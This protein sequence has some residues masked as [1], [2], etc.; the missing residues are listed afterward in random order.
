VALRKVPVAI[1]SG[2]HG[3]GFS[4]GS[5]WLARMTAAP[6]AASDSAMLCE[7]RCD[8]S[9]SLGV[10]EPLSPRVRGKIAQGRRPVD[11]VVGLQ[12]ADGSWDLTKEFAGAV[13]IGRRELEREFDEVMQ[14]LLGHLQGPVAG[15][16]GEDVC[17]RAFAT[18]LALRWL[19]AK[20]VDTRQEWDGLA[21]KAYEWLRLISPSADFWLEAAGRSRALASRP[22]RG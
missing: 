19:E 16:P 21:Q 4:A 5:G 20:C 18:A 22:A 9:F 6:V 1:S 12:G 17:R 2:W 10:M 14:R 8:R 11:R 13:G 7:S 15:G 3:I